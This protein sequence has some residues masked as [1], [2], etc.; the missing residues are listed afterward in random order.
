MDPKIE[1]LI[2]SLN[3]FAEAAMALE[4]AWNEADEKD[5]DAL[6]EGYPFPHSFDE[7][8]FDIVTWCQVAV[9][10]LSTNAG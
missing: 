6:A 2:M 3:D 4:R 10:K 9:S 1:A 8:T 5:S 7:E